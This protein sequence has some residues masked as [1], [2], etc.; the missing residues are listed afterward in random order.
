MKKMS[1]Q[2]N[3]KPNLIIVH[4]NSDTNRILFLILFFVVDNKAKILTLGCFVENCQVYTKKKK[5]TS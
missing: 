2:M 3:S 1:N 4:K 5:K